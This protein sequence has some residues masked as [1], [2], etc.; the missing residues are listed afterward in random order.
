MDSRF[1]GNDGVNAAEFC[2]NKISIFRKTGNISFPRTRR[3]SAKKRR[4]SRESG[5]L[6]GAINF[7]ISA[8]FFCKKRG[9]CRGL[10]VKMDSR[11]RGNDEV[12]A[13]MTAGRRE[14]GGEKLRIKNDESRLFGI[15]RFWKNRL[16]FA[17]GIRRTSLSSSRHNG[18]CFA[19]LTRF[20][21]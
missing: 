14:F 13:G 6:F 21:Y 17:S 19:D 15:L 10:S 9:E 7:G 5:N 20:G 1:R 11:F 3:N 4:H 8:N 16:R 18:N 2:E 12:N